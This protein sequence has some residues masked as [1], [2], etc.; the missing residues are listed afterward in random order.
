MF[1]VELKIVICVAKQGTKG[2][3]ELTRLK[4]SLNI[5]TL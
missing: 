4:R 1:R 5:G 3:L 2:A